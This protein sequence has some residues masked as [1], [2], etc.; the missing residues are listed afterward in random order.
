MAEEVLNQD[1]VDALLN[2]VDSG[3]V[4]TRPEAPPGEARPF[5]FTSQARVVRGR[6]PALEMINERFARLLR[7]SLLN[8]LRRAPEISVKPIKTQTFDVYV[9]SLHVPTSLNMLRINPLR[10]TALVAI[11]PRLVFALID[12]YFGGSGRRASI[13]GRD[14]S[15]TEMQI[16]RTLLD[17]TIGHL[18]EAWRPV[19]EIAVEFLHSEVNP[20]FATCASPTE[21]VVVSAF[22]IELEG[23]GGELHITLP[24]AMLEPL[25]NQLDAGA[26]A[27]SQVPDGRWEHLLAAQIED[28]D[29]ELTTVLGK[30]RSSFG[31]LMNLKPG[32]VLPCDFDG[33]VTAY[34][35]GVPIARGALC[36]HR[37]QH[38]IQVQER[39][40]RKSGNALTSHREAAR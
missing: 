4:E 31:A 14:F 1:E 8:M 7:V 2:G 20:H 35:E 26:P 23:G 13:E 37:G 11:D 19:T 36:E 18:T 39:V 25:R 3:A 30:V 27:D 29:V 21:I 38:A 5:D 12:N 16:I 9:H 17:Q 32:M 34:A 28:A 24:Y 40:R 10:G 22:N 6:M 33:T 15:A